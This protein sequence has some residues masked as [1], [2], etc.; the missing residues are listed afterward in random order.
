MEYHHG[1]PTVHAV[2]GQFDNADRHA[3][4]VLG[5]K[6]KWAAVSSFHTSIARWLGRSGAY[7]VMMNEVIVGS[8][9][10]SEGKD[11]AMQKLMNVLLRCGTVNRDT[12]P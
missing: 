9:C 2:G 7:D 3:L 10:M 5:T 4:L 8:G 11:K 1:R 6:P 12:P